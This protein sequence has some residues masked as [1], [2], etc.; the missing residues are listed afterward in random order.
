V[1]R[2]HLAS[3]APRKRPECSRCRGSLARCP[4]GSGWSACVKEYHSRTAPRT[5]ARA[6]VPDARPPPGNCRGPLASLSLSPHSP[7][8]CSTRAYPSLRLRD[9]SV[10]YRTPRCDPHLPPILRCQKL[11]E[12]DS[13]SEPTHYLQKQAYTVYGYIVRGPPRG[14]DSLQC[15]HST[16][17]RQLAPGGP[18][19]RAARRGPRLRAPLGADG[20]MQMNASLC[21]PAAPPRGGPR[22]Y[23]LHRAWPAILPG[24][25]LIIIVQLH[26]MKSNTSRDLLWCDDA[27]P[28]ICMRGTVTSGVGSGKISC[29]HFSSSPALASRPLGGSTGAPAQSDNRHLAVA[30]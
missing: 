28:S 10:A 20:R 17:I 16:S 9:S 14:Y 13:S 26:V 29:F 22:E 6:R 30:E 7:S 27:M 11:L 8:R 23:C 5:V 21:L 12:S 24:M 2:Y 4:L 1:A 25:I 19:P 3:Q 18:G 15:V